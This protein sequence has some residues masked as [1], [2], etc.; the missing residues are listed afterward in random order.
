MKGETDVVTVES[1]AFNKAMTGTWD[2]YSLG[3]ASQSFHSEHA[4]SNMHG[5]SPV[6]VG[7]WANGGQN[8]RVGS[9]DD[10]TEKNVLKQ[11]TG[12]TSKKTK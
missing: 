10:L 11:E 2:M 8:L 6:T 5:R 3:R 1:Y 9:E 12:G 4:G 7:T